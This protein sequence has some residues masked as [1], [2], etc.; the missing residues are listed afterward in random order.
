[1]H[2]LTTAVYLDIK[3]KVLPLKGFVYFQFVI[4]ED[5]YLPRLV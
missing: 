3:Y 1:M 5:L 2:L 4:L